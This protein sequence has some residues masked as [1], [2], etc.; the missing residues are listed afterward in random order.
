MD[1]AA[2]KSSGL[3]LIKSINN[4]ESS[5]YCAVMADHI[6]MQ[7]F[8]VFRGTEC[9]KDILTDINCFQEKTSLYGDEFRVHDGFLKA[10]KSIREQLHTVPMTDFD[11]YDIVTCGHSL[12]GALATLCGVYLPIG[13]NKVYTITFGSPRVGNDKFV[14]VFNK[15]V[16]LYNRF[17]HDADL[18]PQVPKIN[19]QHAG[20]EIRLD[21]KGNEISYFNLWKRLLYWIKGKQSLDLEMVS[22][23]DHLMDS[24]IHTVTLWCSKLS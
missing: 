10:Y 5:T 23:K 2:L 11:N 13:N 1:E 4:R 24:Y 12:G 3:Q 15:R 8:I 17:V 20:K 22:I 16:T 7:L 18:V 21:D 19:Y 14:K 9:E 6:N